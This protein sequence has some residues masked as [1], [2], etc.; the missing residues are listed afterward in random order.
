M[1]N[2]TP[3][4]C[5]ACHKPMTSCTG[6]EVTTDEI[7]AAVLGLHNCENALETWRRERLGH[8]VQGSAVTKEHW[9]EIWT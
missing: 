4:T 8:D 1:P 5:P 2:L 9:D 3:A 6:C 7:F